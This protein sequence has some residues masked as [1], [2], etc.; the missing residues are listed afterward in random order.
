M[1]M[2]EAPETYAREA[3]PAA[4]PVAIA[5]RR[6]LPTQPRVVRWV[7]RLR[8]AA[9]IMIALAAVSGLVYAWMPE[10]I[11]VDVAAVSVGPLQ[12][13]VD[14]D[15]RTRVKD[16]YT[17]SAP[18]MA[19][20]ARIELRPGDRVQ[21]GKLLARL[22][23]LDPPLLD[24]R[25]RALQQA[26]IAAALASRQ[27][28][29]SAI[30][31]ARAALDFAQ[32]EVA[33][34][35][36]LNARGASAERLRARAELEARSLSQDLASTQFGARV[37]DYEVQ[38]ARLALDR[39]RDGGNAEQIEIV[40]PVDGQVL[41]VLQ[42]SAAVVQPG[43][44]LIELGDLRAL[45]VV[46]DVLTSEAVSIRPGANATI[47]H[48]GGAL[49]MAAHVRA[50][51]PSAFTRI[52]ALGVEEQRVNVLLELDAPQSQWATLGDGYRVET[53]IEIWSGAAV[54]SAP[55]SAVFRQ[56]D[57]WASYRLQSGRTQLVPVEI[58]QRNPERVEIV[59]GLAAGDTVV[60]HPSER[61]ADGARVVPR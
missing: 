9:L 47:E 16:R 27:Q 31:R 57:Q 24:A 2:T 52:S 55:A 36:E 17:I 33:R 12:V 50:I 7:H 60:V 3:A 4:P 22:V 20:L 34:E 28:A 23:P 48:W 40:S 15:A 11:P 30:E 37:A 35:R 39:Q 5:P 19:T 61:L 18:L 54:L 46:A 8:G 44:P 14:E 6:A 51:E 29:E 32:T 58:G 49:P 13:T 41:R 10:P 21:S 53:R 38:M 1:S 25:T 45:E 56:G 26:R 43:S 42:E 59:R